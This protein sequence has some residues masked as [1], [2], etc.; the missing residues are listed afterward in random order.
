VCLETNVKI[1]KRIQK[2]KTTNHFQKG[3]GAPPKGNKRDNRLE[4]GKGDG[5]QKG[6]N[7]TKIDVKQPPVGDSEKLEGATSQPQ[8]A[9]EV[10]IM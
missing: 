5:D 2:I 10:S 9:T 4:G 6:N 1:K 7:T 3:A 8:A